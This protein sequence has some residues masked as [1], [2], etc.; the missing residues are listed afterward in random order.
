LK[1]LQIR[2]ALKDIEGRH[3]DTPTPRHADTPT[4]A[5]GLQPLPELEPRLP[6]AV[7]HKYVSVGNSAV[8]DPE[9]IADMTRNLTRSKRALCNVARHAYNDHRLWRRMAIAAKPMRVHPADCAR[10][11]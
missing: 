8:L 6:Q 2:T 11:P 5:K 7:A 9:A 10:Q 3:P 1:S 4:L